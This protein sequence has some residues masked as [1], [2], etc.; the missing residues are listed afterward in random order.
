[1]SKIKV[2]NLPRLKLEDLLRRRKTTLAKHMKEFGITTYEGLLERCFRM[3]V[4][5]PSQQQFLSVAPTVV[6]NPQEG[7]VVLEAP[8]VIEEA[9]GKKITDDIVT[10]FDVGS[11]GSE[12]EAVDYT[13]KKSK[14]KKDAQVG[15]V[16]E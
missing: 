4:E 14:R 13:K 8:P 11:I 9:T 10:T 2:K 7:V 1:M 16:N 3:G 6:N 12:L 5:P 15:D